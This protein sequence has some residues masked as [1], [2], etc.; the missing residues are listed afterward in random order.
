MDDERFDEAVAFSRRCL[1]S[2]P[3]RGRTAGEALAEVLI[4]NEASANGFL[5]AWTGEQDPSGAELARARAAYGGGNV[6]LALLFYSSSEEAWAWDALSAMAQSAVRDRTQPL[7]SQIAGWLADEL[8]GHRPR[9]TTGKM[10]LVCRDL[11]VASTIELLRWSYDL[12]PT[13][14][15]DRGDRC[16]AEG[17]S[18]CDAIGVAL[19]LAYKNVERIWHQWGEQRAAAVKEDGA[20]RFR[21]SVGAKSERR[22]PTLDEWVAALPRS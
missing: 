21:I 8:A 22:R 17:G 5:M 9:P 12:K 6:L 16:S 11:V 19:T 13:R 7:P 1:D 10:T 15:S 14:S 3:Y 20:E 4:T 18:G 2:S